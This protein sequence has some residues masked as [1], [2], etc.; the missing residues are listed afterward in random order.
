VI[1]A[2]EI[3]C[4]YPNLARIANDNTY[5]NA[6]PDAQIMQEQLK[7]LSAGSIRFGGSA[8]RNPAL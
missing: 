7:R 3:A 2:V 8:T 5:Q 1:A 6:P 4:F